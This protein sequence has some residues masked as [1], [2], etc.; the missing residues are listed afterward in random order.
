MRYFQESVDLRNGKNLQPIE[1]KYSLPDQPSGNIVFF[2]TGSFEY[3]IEQI[4]QLPPPRTHYQ[5]I[6]IPTKFQRKVGPSVVTYQMSPEV[7]RQHVEYIQKQKR[8]Y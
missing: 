3:D 1:T 5:T 4:K 7:Y 6:M 2:I 8:Y